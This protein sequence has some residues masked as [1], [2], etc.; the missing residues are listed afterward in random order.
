MEFRNQKEIDI[1]S[2]IYGRHPFLGEYLKEA[3]ETN[4]QREFGM[5][6]HSDPVY[7]RE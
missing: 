6:G 5:Y 4:F 3:C 2:Q 7:R 1:S